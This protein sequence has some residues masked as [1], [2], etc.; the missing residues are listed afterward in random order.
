MSKKTTAYKSIRTPIDDFLKKYSGKKP[1][2]LHMPG[3]KGK[4]VIN[5]YD[6]TEVDGADSLYYARGIIKE[7]EE[8]ASEIFASNTFYSTEGSS[9]CIRAMVR[10]I[11]EYAYYKGETPLI[12]AVRNAHRSFISALALTG[13]DVKWL[14]GEKTGNYLSCKI[15]AETFETLFS[16]AETLPTAVYLTSPDYLGVTADIEGISRVCKKYGV[17]LAVDNAHGAYLKFLTPSAHPID[18]GA[19]MCSDSAHKT[20]NSLTGSAY[21][22]I[23][24]SAPEILVEKAKSA[25]ALFGSTSP[26]YLILQS[27][28]KLNLILGNGYKEELFKFCTKLRSLKASLKIFGYELIGDEEL[29]I[30]VKCKEYGYRGREINEILKSENFIPDFYDDD[31]V[32]MMFTPEITESKL[33]KLLKVFKSIPQK[34]PIIDL[35]PNFSSPRKA[36]SVAEAYK[37]PTERISVENANG[38]ILAEDEISC[39]PAVPLIVAGEIIDEKIISAMK[40][41]NIAEIKV[42]SEGQV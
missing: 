41:Y 27:L 33:K 7:S 32:V 21:L 22:H 12:F 26:S 31:Y 36:M 18:L 20:L 35:Y 16:S 6:I 39:P 24:K 8:I 37:K 28:D 10:L 34:E 5:R 11:C 9:H 4:G 15:T 29:K 13:C 23:S 30:T 17:L 40:Y 14:Y 3:H 42:V 38:R 1:V 19:D 2:R 25:L